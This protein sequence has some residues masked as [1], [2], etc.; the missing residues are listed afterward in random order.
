[1]PS[2]WNEFVFVLV[3]P[4]EFRLEHIVTR[5]R[6]PH[7]SLGALDKVQSLGLLHLSLCWPNTNTFCGLLVG[8]G[9]RKNALRL[10]VFDEKLQF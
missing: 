3:V 1:M 8:T 2:K 10:W 6:K 7:V 4:I 5:K 9:F